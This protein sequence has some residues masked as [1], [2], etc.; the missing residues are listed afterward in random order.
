MKKA[1]KQ[2]FDSLQD[3]IT[4]FLMSLKKKDRWNAGIDLCMLIASYSIVEPVGDAKDYNF[5]EPLE[6][7]DIAKTELTSIIDEELLDVI[8]EEV[9]K[10][11]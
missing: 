5:F 8:G 2:I 11:L 6:I 10:T 7:L 4:G 1:D 9:N 3:D